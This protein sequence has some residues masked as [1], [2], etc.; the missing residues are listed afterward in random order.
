MP[1]GPLLPHM[2]LGLGCRVPGGVCEACPR[3][4][5]LGGHVFSWWLGNLAPGPV[6]L[7]AAYADITRA[8]LTSLTDKK[9]ESSAPMSGQGPRPPASR[10][11]C[12]PA[13]DPG[14]QHCP[15]GLRT[16]P[17]CHTIPAQQLLFL[18]DWCR[19]PGRDPEFSWET[20][21]SRMS[22]ARGWEVGLGH[23]P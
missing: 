16:A 15:E 10:A 23:L 12:P 1:R 14:L 19:L 8:H 7:G 6:N 18:R 2:I 3:D 11:P 5:L 4:P 21:E 17:S 22:G 9:A 13:F 20:L